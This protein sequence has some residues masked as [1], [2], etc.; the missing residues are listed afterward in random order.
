MRPLAACAMV[1]HRTL[2]EFA[3][4]VRR[5]WLDLTQGASPLN[6][7]WHGDETPWVIRKPTEPYDSIFYRGESDREARAAWLDGLTQGDADLAEALD[8]SGIAARL[9]AAERERPHLRFLDFGQA[10]AAVVGAPFDTI[11]R[12]YRALSAP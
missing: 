7:W 1:Y 10:G 12:A 11:W 4:D 9:S 8:D 3:R 2:R 6:M 5:T